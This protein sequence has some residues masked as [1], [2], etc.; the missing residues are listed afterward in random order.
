M[1][2]SVL[3]PIIGLLKKRMTEEIMRI[4]KRSFTGCDV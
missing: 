2:H 3:V 1:I 4:A